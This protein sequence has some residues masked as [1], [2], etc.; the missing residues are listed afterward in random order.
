MGMAHSNGSAGQSGMTG[1]SGV[2]RSLDSVSPIDL[3]DLPAEAQ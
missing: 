1:A 3:G 2:S